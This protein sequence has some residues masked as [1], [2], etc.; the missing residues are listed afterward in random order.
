VPNTS[1][2]QIRKSVRNR[3]LPILLAELRTFVN[4]VAELGKIKS[5]TVY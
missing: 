5:A 1:A 2:G 4:A 3:K